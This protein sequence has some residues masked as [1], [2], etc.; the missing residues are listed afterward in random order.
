MMYYDYNKRSYLLPPGCKDLIDL[1]KLEQQK[2]PL[3]IKLPMH[4]AETAFI[5]GVDEFLGVWKLKK[6][7]PTKSETASPASGT[8]LREVTIPETILVMELAK[9]AGQKPFKII[10]DLME[11][12]VFANMKQKVRFDSASRVLKKYGITAKKAP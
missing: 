4:P 8:S 1:L 10:A 9:V 11:I 7:K 5:P 3:P 12:G 6:K 2:K